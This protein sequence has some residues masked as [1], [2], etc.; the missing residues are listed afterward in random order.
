LKE[1]I[2][3]KR[4]NFYLTNTTAGLAILTSIAYFYAGLSKK[5]FLVNIISTSKKSIKYK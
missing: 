1:C 5:G 3:Y 4:R 2:D